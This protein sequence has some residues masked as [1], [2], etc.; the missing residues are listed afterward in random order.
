MYHTPQPSTFA[1]ARRRLR[2]PLVLGTPIVAFGALFFGV[3]YAASPEPDVDIEPGIALATVD[4]R[5]VVLVPYGRHGARGMF[6]LMTKDMFQARVAATDAATG[7]VL[8]DKQVSDA[9]IWDATVLATGDKYA[10]LTTDTGLL[11]FD[12]HTGDIVAKGDG[13]EGLGSAF[14]AAPSAYGYDAENRRVMAM[15]AAGAVVAIPLDNPVAAPVD[16]ATA[17]AWT[18]RLAANGRG[19]STPRISASE[20]ALGGGV[21]VEAR[22]RPNGAPG[23]VLVRVGED[24]TETPVGNTVFFDGSLV[25]GPAPSD[26]TA[27]AVGAGSG[28]VLVRH[29]R[30]VNDGGTALSAVSLDSGAVTSTLPLGSNPTAVDTG[31]DGTVVVSTGDSLAVLTTGGKLTELT[32]GATDFFGSPS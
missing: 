17:D 28:Y 30:S 19:R 16:P 31:A 14:I 4:G 5:E 10:Y 23:K 18:T 21:T 8:W 26:G 15:T 24:G 6:Q 22:E 3:S 27:P 9:L 12:V 1:R 32:V 13:V 25:V 20:A 2:L 7:E 11:V 29:D